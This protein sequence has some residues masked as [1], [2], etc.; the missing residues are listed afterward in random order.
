MLQKLT[1]LFSLKQ[2][3]RFKVFFGEKLFF[4]SILLLNYKQVL[5]LLQY[6]FSY[7][8]VKTL[9]KPTAFFRLLVKYL[10]LLLSLGQEYFLLRGFMLIYSSKMGRRLSARTN[11]LRFKKGYTSLTNKM[12]RVETQKF[13]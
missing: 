7:L 4:L 1:E 11:T 9:K 3:R 2:H 8:Q 5:P 10:S 6:C 12:L 13:Y